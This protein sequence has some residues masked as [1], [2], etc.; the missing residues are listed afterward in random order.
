[1]CT[2]T[3]WMGE[4]HPGERE[5]SWAK[6]QLHVSISMT[7]AAGKDSGLQHTSVIVG[8]MVYLVHV[9]AVGTVQRSDCNATMQATGSSIVARPVDSREWLPVDG[10]QMAVFT[11]DWL[12]MISGFGALCAV[13][14]LVSGMSSC[15]HSALKMC[16]GV[17]QPN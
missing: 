2:N 13:A 6:K 1:M 16:I 17:H 11:S 15:G 4:S 5:A 8:N 14:C 7:G 9:R 12:G 10:P 3:I